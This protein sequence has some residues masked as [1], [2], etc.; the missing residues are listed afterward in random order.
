MNRVHS[1]EKKMLQTYNDLLLQ[2]TLFTTGK[3]PTFKVKRTSSWSA[4]IGKKKFSRTMMSCSSSSLC[5]LSN[6][7]AQCQDAFI[8]VLD[9]ECRCQRCQ[10]VATDSMPSSLSADSQSDFPAM[11]LDKKHNIHCMC[12][13]KH[14]LRRTQFENSSVLDEYTNGLTDCCIFGNMQKSNY[15]SSENTSLLSSA[16][17]IRNRPPSPV[18]E[19]LFLWNE[20]RDV[21]RYESELHHSTYFLRH[22]DS[23][24][25][26]DGGHELESTFP[27]AAFSNKRAVSRSSDDTESNWSLLFL[28]ET[29][30]SQ[31]NGCGEPLNEFNY[32]L[33]E[34]RS[35]NRA[36]V[37]PD[38]TSVGCTANTDMPDAEAIGR[39]TSRNYSC[40]LSSKVDTHKAVQPARERTSGKNDFLQNKLVSDLSENIDQTN[41]RFPSNWKNKQGKTSRFS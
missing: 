16:H 39:V 20:H 34:S 35:S 7:G 37:A 12:S 15:P 9:E 5:T 14:L 2:H 28:T 10:K 8:G 36:S 19:P 18:N 4:L 6:E 26:L 33:R 3:Q 31:E 11:V 21:I 40:R 30:L 23:I 25:S 27:N 22:T 13:R 24:E 29:D 1:E 32:F 41:K 17:S 38:V